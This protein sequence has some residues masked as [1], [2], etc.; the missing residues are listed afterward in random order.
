M[1]AGAT[2]R[3]LTGRETIAALDATGLARSSFVVSDGGQLAWRDFEVQPARQTRLALAWADPASGALLV[4]LSCSPRL[5]SASAFVQVIGWDEG[6]TVFNFY[7]RRRGGWIWAGNSRHALDAPTRGRGPFDS[8]VNGALV[9][10]ELKVPWQHWSSQS[11][12]DLPGLAPDNPLRTEDVFRDRS[13]AERLEQL[14]RS[15]VQR[16]TDARLAP[17]VAEGELTNAH[18]FLRQVVDTTSVNLVS[19]D[20]VSRVEPPPP[21]LTLPTTAFLDVDALVDLLE[22]EVTHGRLSTSW[23]HY[24]QVLVD[25]GYELRAGGDRVVARGDLHFA[26]TAP[27]RAF[28]DQAVLRALVRARLLSRRMAASLLMVDFPNPVFSRRRRSLLAALPERGVRDAGGRWSLD[29][30]I[31]DVTSSAASAGG[32]AEE[33]LRAW[34][35]GDDWQRAFGARIDAYL[36]ALQA[37]LDTS[38]GFAE[39]DRLIVS[40]RRQA[41]RRPLLEFDLTLP[42]ARELPRE[43]LAMR[44]DGS[45][46]EEET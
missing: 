24:Q 23:E 44:E 7:E 45:I 17:V 42:F 34:A 30:A 20:V 29:D 6:A 19:S 38:S 26:F 18:T 8:H 22:V 15:G 37:R 9:M 4:L 13:G 3:P 21:R 35:V 39:I 16:W 31:L 28:E 14:V 25:H 36:T 40:R 33:L 10:K 46:Y 43:Q 1:L 5:D 11:A 2:T 32:P 27:E 12:F 41:R